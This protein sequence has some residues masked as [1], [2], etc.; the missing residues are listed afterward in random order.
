M[1]TSCCSCSDDAFGVRQSIL[2]ENG[3]SFKLTINDTDKDCFLRLD[4]FDRGRVSEGVLRPTVCLPGDV[5]IPMVGVVR[6]MGKG[7]VSISI[8]Q[9]LVV[10]CSVNS[11]TH[12][13]TPPLSSLSLLF[14]L[15]SY[16]LFFSLPW[17]HL[18]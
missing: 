6:S 8:M 15:F 10:T 2:F 5:I 16:S 17:T 14:L 3:P 13:H 7:L 11:S 12:T 9:M 4:R 1:D 18:P